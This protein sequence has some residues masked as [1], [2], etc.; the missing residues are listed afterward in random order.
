V[1]INSEALNLAM[2][3]DEFDADTFDENVDTESHIEEDDEISIND[4]DEENMQPSVDTA[5]DA[6]V[7]TVDEDNGQNVPSSVAA[8]CD[9]STSSR[10]N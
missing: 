5:T 2:V 7:G 8:Q 4:S 1:K 10:I 3:T 9:V 6:S